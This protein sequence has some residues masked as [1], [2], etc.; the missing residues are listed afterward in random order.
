MRVR[1]IIPPKLRDGSRGK[2]LR[3]TST[4]TGGRLERI[5]AGGFHR[6]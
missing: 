6:M 3:E 2:G 1:F 4:R 5:P